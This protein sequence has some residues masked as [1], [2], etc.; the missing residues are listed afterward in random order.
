MAQ[1]EYATVHLVGAGPGD[2]DLLTVRAARLI[3]EAAVIVHDGLVSDEILALADPGAERISVAKQRDRHSLPQDQI[4]ALLVRLAQSGRSVVR[5]KGGDPFIF[6]RGGEEL[7]ACRAAGVPVEVVPGI[8][9]AIGSAAQA[10][11]PLT[12]RDASSA[13]SFVAGQCKGLADQ[14]WSG[15]AGKGRTLVIYMGVATAADIADKLIADGV[16]PATPIAVLENGTRTDMRTL[17]SLLADL[18]HLMVREQVKS[19]ALIVVG[20]VAAY[21]LALDVLAGW[22]AGAE[23]GAE[24]IL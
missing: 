6:G 8:S 24:I 2:P 23:N 21:A 11:L 18:G 5:L 4:N 12:H 19:P 17:R 10:Q 22:S 1:T 13:V 16:S 7:E 9:A 15:L 14:D 20:E 3:G